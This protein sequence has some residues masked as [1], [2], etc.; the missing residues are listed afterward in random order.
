MSVVYTSDK[1]TS[2]RGG[3]SP[4]TVVGSSLGGGL[5]ELWQPSRTVAQRDRAASASVI[6]PSS[7]NNRRNFINTV[8]TG[9]ILISSGGKSNT[10]IVGHASIMAPDDWVLEMPGGTSDGLE[11][12]N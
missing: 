8:K 5:L 10:G 3:A 12:N 9:D 11:D 6:F 1:T 7:S 4:A 2:R